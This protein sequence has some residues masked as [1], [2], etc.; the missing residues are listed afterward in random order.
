MT[1]IDAH[2][3]FE[4]AGGRFALAVRDAR[5]VVPAM[6]VREL[7]GAPEIVVGAID[8]HG[9]VVPVVDLHVRFGAPARPMRAADCFIIAH[10][11]R[12]E[13]ALWVDRV[14]GLE[15]LAAGDIIAATDVVPELPHVRGLMRGPEGLVLITDLERVLSLE[16][17]RRLDAALQEG[18]TA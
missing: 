17:S 3:V 11:G 12:R 10:A 6:L 14:D 18:V 5:R 1:G 16:E 9:Q 8:L 13:V 4:V 2:L 7:P 15:E